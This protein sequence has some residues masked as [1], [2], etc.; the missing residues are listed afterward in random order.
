MS[1]IPQPP[2]TINP[3]DRF[4]RWT[5]LEVLGYR[6]Y[7]GGKHLREYRAQCDCGAIRIL[8]RHNLLQ[9]RTLSCGCLKPA[10]QQVLQT[11]H[12]DYKTRLYGV[13]TQMKERCSNPHHTSFN[14]YGGRGITVCEEWQD[15]PTFRDWANAN[16]YEPGLK[17]D[18]K[19]NDGP[20]YPTNCRWVDNFTQQQNTS[21]NVN[22]TAFGET[23]CASE[24]R[25]DPRCLVS[26]MT[27]KAR[28]AAGMDA[29]T[30]MSTPPRNSNGRGPSRRR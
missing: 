1:I 6:I 14:R 16:G 5:I 7:A 9:G 13:W 10:L 3:G 15:Y 8:L 18:R 2:P 11:T 22:I 25:R 27:I 21:W 28:M 24:W 29:E 20:Y 26:Q 19:D 17:L 4:G 30:A 12:G 23:K